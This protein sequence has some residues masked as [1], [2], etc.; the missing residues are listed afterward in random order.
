MGFYQFS[1]MHFEKNLDKY[2]KIFRTKN[3]K[4]IIQEWKNHSDTIGQKIIINTFNEQIKGK[5]IDINQLGFLKVILDT[6]KLK[7]ISSGEFIFLED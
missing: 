1:F 5:V 3:F 4:H 7:I 6:G 2:Y